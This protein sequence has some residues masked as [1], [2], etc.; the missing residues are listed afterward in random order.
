M[1]KQIRSLFVALALALPNL[2]LAQAATDKGNGLMAQVDVLRCYRRMKFDMEE[3]ARNVKESKDATLQEK[4]MFEEEYARLRKGFNHFVGEVGD[5][6]DEANGQPMNV[7]DLNKGQLKELMALYRQYETSFLQRYEEVMGTHE[8]PLMEAGFAE[9]VQ[10][11]IAR[12]TVLTPTAYR[13]T[14]EQDLT[15]TTWGRL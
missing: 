6:V 12:T 15:V 2:C 9:K 1:K 8:H 3:K 11:C 7:C 4:T 5:R 14:Y 10:T 13:A